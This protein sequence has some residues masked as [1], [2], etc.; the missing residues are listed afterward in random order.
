ME[1]STAYL[2]QHDPFEGLGLKRPTREPFRYPVSSDLKRELPDIREALRNQ[3]GDLA[4]RSVQDQIQGRLFE[5]PIWKQ[6]IGEAPRVPSNTPLVIEAGLGF[7]RDDTLSRVLLV[8]LSVSLQPENFVPPY[9]V[10]NKAVSEVIAKGGASKE[11]HSENDSPAPPHCAGFFEEVPPHTC[12]FTCIRPHIGGGAE[13]TVLNLEAVL[14]AAPH[15]LIEEWRNG[16]FEFRTSRRLGME[17]KPLK[18]LSF[19]EGLPFLRYRKEYMPC[20]EQSRALQLLEEL[21]TNPSNH[22][23]IPLQAGE[24]L[25]HWNGAPHSRLPQHGDTPE[26]ISAR[27][28]LIRCRSVPKSG[29]DSHFKNT[30]H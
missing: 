18:L 28:K 24:T 13:T 6:W 19:I 7:E 29:W 12:Y 1:V 27:R 15:A 2:N 21:V 14:S 26:N 16:S 4:D 8:G 25:I 23:V 11:S 17:T 3:K 22:F 30:H 20:F 5:F 10:G 9:S